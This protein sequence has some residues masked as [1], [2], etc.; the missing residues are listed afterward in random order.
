MARCLIVEDS[1]MIRMIAKRMIEGL[2]HSVIEAEGPAEASDMI[3]DHEPDVV[4]LDWDLPD[5]GALDFLRAVCS[6]HH[7]PRPTI[8]LCATEN[9]PRQMALAKAA[10]AP[11]HILKPYDHHTLES[12]MRKAGFASMIDRVAPQQQTAAIAS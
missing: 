12:V 1:E 4:F 9:D 3:R 2:G 5:L 8:I 6:Q 7:R 10:G 11:F